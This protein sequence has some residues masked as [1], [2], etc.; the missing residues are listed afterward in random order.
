MLAS[1]N[2]FQE[3]PRVFFVGLSIK[4]DCKHLDEDTQTGNVVAKIIQ[5]IPSVSSI[6]TNLVKK[7]P[8]DRDGKLRYPNSKEMAEGWRLLR[9]DID[10]ASP[11]LVVT[12]GQQVSTFLR[13]QLGIRPEKPYLPGDYS[14]R[15][16][17]LS[18]N[19]E[20]LPVH[21]PS[22]IYIYRR[23]Y[24]DNYVESIVQSIEASLSSALESD[25]KVIYETPT[26]QKAI[27]TSIYEE[28]NSL[29][30]AVNT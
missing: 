19:V 21:H 17:L 3:K 11:R 16:C 22:Y 7:P 26:D 18:N 30:F 6:K 15:S 28:A 10:E 29:R 20:M 27:R 14:Y 13:L 25:P 23:K 2:K 5:N 1:G 12:L 24:I 4:P 9:R 8:L